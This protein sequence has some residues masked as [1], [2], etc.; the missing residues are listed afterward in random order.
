MKTN[1][2]IYKKRSPNKYK[3]E[4]VTG[5]VKQAGFFLKKILQRRKELELL[6]ADEK[7]RGF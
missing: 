7:A 6:F 4:K 5:Y 2:H 1:I 3:Q